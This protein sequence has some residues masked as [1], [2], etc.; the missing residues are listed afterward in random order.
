MIGNEEV[1]A[2]RRIMKKPLSG[3]RASWGE[4][5]F[6][7]D[8]VKALEAE[9]A[10]YFKVKHAI[11]FNSATSALWAALAI[12]IQQDFTSIMRNVERYGRYIP[13]EVIVTPYSMPASASLPLHFGAKPVFADIEKDYYCLDPKEVEKKI[14]WRTKAIVVV[15]LFGMPY[16]ADTINAIAKKHGILVIEDAAQAPFAKYK[17]KYA[18]T[19][20]S[21]LHQAKAGLLLQTMMNTQ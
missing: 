16:D 19:F 13:D 1:N 11:C 7:G 5:F 17:G 21:L 15:D 8:E 6:G 9:W 3:Y 2:I 4:W 10:E 14:T 18:G 12:Q 20:I